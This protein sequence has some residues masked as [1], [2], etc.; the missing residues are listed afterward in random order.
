MNHPFERN[1]LKILGLLALSEPCA[2]GANWA[3]DTAP[4][5]AAYGGGNW[6]S[7]TTPGSG[8][9]TPASG[10]SLYFGTSSV[11]TLTNNDSN[12]TFGGFTYN[13]GAN[14][15]TNIGN[16]FTLLG[17][18][19][20]SSASLQ[21]ISNNIVLAANGT[22]SLAGGSLTLAGIISDGGSGYSLTRN[23]GSGNTLTLAGANTFSGAINLNAGT[24]AISSAGNL[25]NGTNIVCGSASTS[26]ISAAGAVTIPA[27]TTITAGSGAS[28]SAKETG[29]AATFQIAAL[30]TGAGNGAESSSLGTVWFSNPGNNYTGNFSMGYGTVEFNSVANGG[31][32]SSLGAG[33]TAY[34]IGN[35]SSAAMF[36]YL[37]SG[38]GTTTR[39][40]NW[41]ATT[42]G[43]ALDS[44]GSGAVQFL[45]TNAFRSAGSGANTL[46]LSGT[47][48][49]A[50]TLGQVI[51]DSAV[52]GA[53]T[54]VKTGAGT[55]ILS[56]TNTFSGATTISAGVLQL[57][58]G[59]ARNGSV[60]GAII[61]NASLVFANPTALNT[62]NSISGPGPLTKNAG[63]LL[64]LSGTNTYTGATMINSGTLAIGPTG[65][66]GGSPNIDLA[67]GAGFDVSAVSGG[68]TLAAGQ[69]L[70][71]V[72]GT[73]TING[74]LNL[75]SSSLSLTNVPG[76]P[77]FTVTGGALTLNNNSITV[78]VPGNPTLAAGSY[79]LIA[80]GSGGSVAGSVA[81]SPLALID[82]GNLNQPVA[83]AITN[84]GLW[85]VVSAT[86]TVPTVTT[87][88]SS[89]NP[90]TYG[91]VP[92]TFTATVS[93]APA[94]GE[95][96]AFLDGTNYL[97]AGQLTN[98]TAEFS[99]GTLALGSHAITAFFGQDVL[100]EA[101]TSGVLTQVVNQINVCYPQGTGF[102]LLMY[103]VDS[104]YTNLSVYGWNV[105]QQYGLVTNTD[106]NNFLAGLQA[107]DQTGPA[108]IPCSGTNDPFTG[109]TQA[110][111]QSWV[112]SIDGNTNIAWWS[113]PEQLLP[114]Y[115]TETNLL[116][117]YLTWTRQYDPQQRPCYEYTENSFTA[118]DMSKIIIYSDIVAVSCY[119]EQI[120]M[121]H[122][123]VRYKLQQVG[124]GGA[125]LAGKTLGP[126]Y[127]AG[128]K[129]LIGDL[130]IAEYPNTNNYPTEPTPA[131][132]YHD[133]W[134]AIASG[135]QGI[136]VY[137]YYH[138][139]N[140]DPANL[141]NCLL[142]ANIAASQ[143]TG[144]EQIGSV[145]LN[146]TPNT[147]V[148]F[149][150]TAGP[151]NTVAFMP[152]GVSTNIQYPSINVLSKTW[153]GNVYVIAVN[154]TSSNVTAVITNLPV[155]ES[156]AALPFEARL[157]T[158]TNRSFTDTFA[159]WGVHIYKLTTSTD[160]WAGGS[161]SK[162]STGTNWT[163][164]SGNGPVASGDS[165][166]FA[167]A[168]STAPTND[169]TGFTFNGITFESGAGAYTINGNA[170]TLS[171]GLANGSTNTQTINN[172]ILLATNLALDLSGG[173]LTLAGAISDGGNGFGL[174]RSGGSGNTLTLAGT[175]TFSG[176]VTLNGG[177]L[178]IG[179]LTNLGGGG[180]LICGGGSVSTV[181]AA[182]AVTIPSA[183]TVSVGGGASF[184][185][186][187]TTAFTTFQIA[188]QITGAGN[189]N[190]G[191]SAGTVWFSNPGNNYTGNFTMGYGTFQFSSVANGGTASSLGAGT[192]AY[193]IG[194]SASTA[195][196][197]YVGTGAS[198]TTRAIN[199]TAN[200]GALALD[201]GG[202]G[203]V[204]FLA[205]NLLRSGG[206][207]ADTLTL[208]GASTGA[209]TLAQVINDSPV[210]GA[211]SLVKAGA[212][213]W[214]LTGTNTYSGPTT[215]TGGTLQV[216]GTLGTNAVTVTNATLTGTG[217]VAGP[218]TFQSGSTL[219][220]GDN[221]I[222]TLSFG[223]S[224]TMNSGSLTLLNLSKN[225]G[226]LAN[227]A[228]AVTGALLLNGSLTVTN[229]G[230]NGLAAGDSFQI[231]SA[232]SYS[233]T[234]SPTLPPLATGLY[235][236]TN[237]LTVNGT[238]AVSN[239][240][241]TLAYV[242]GGGGSISGNAAQTVNYGTSGTA[243]TALP[244]TGYSFVNW[245][246]GS[247]ANP[248]TD[249]NVT[250][251]LSVTANFAINVY[252][253]TYTAGANGT[254]GGT[255]PQLVD[256]GANGTAVTAVPA[257][258]YHFVNWSDSSTAN[259][260]T[261][262]NV[263]GNIT[264]TASFAINT[265]TLT[266]SA[267][268]GGTVAGT[269]PQTVNYGASGTAMTATADAGLHFAGWSDG[270]TSNPRTDTDVTSNVT[271]TANF[272]VSTDTWAGATGNAFSTVANWSY[273]IFSGPVGTGDSLIFAAAGS[274]TPTN[275][276]TGLML[277]NIIFSNGASAYVINGNGF[278]LSGS[279]SNGAAN[280]QI[281]S[282]NIVLGT[283]LAVNL[284]AGSLTLAGSISDGG[285]GFSLTRASSGSGN[286]LTLA[287]AN[288]FTGGIYL[289]AGT[290]A[291]SSL[292]NLGGGNS[293]TCGGAS[294]SVLSAGGAITL[295]ATTTVTVGSG[296]SFSAK[297]ATSGMTFQVA[298]LITGTGNGNQSSSSGTVWLS[299]TGNNYTGNFGMG[300]GTLQYSSVAN[301]GTASAL[302]A[303][304]TA[305]TIGNS[306]SS[307]T[308]GYVG[309]GTSTTTRAINW[310]ATTG[311]LALDASGG[312]PVQFLATNALRSTGSGADTLTL[313]G[314]NT[315]ANTLAQVINDSAVAGATTLVK[316]GA[317][318]WV[319]TGANTC[320][321][322]TMVNG[323]TLQVDGSLGTNTVTVANTAVLAG[324]GTLGGATTV[325]SGGT[326]APGDG[327]IGTLN[328]G[329]SLALNGGS[330]SSLSLSKNGGVL[331]N[332]QVSV[333][334]AL[335]EGGLLAVANSGTNALAAGDSCRLFKA[336]SYAGGFTNVTLPAL[337]TGLTWYTNNLP[338]NGTIAVSN[339]TFTLTYTAGANGS[340][341]GTSPQTVI[342]GASGTAVTA[343]ANTN[344][345]F[346]KWSDG[347]G[348][349]PRTDTGVTNNITVS[350]IFTNGLPTLWLTNKVG[351]ISAAVTAGYSGKTFTL[352]GT[353]TG[354]ATNADG[355]WFAYLPATN[356]LSITAQV[357]S[358]QTNGTAP[359]AGVMIR[360]DTNAGSVFAFLGLS[361]TNN[362][363]W[364]Y[365]T[366][367]N[368]V[369]SATTFTNMPAPYW[370]QIIRGTNTFTSYVS[371]NGTAW[372]QAASVTITNMAT[373]VLVGL[374]VSAGTS[375]TLN[376][377]VFNNVV[378]TNNG[379]ILFQPEV[380]GAPAAAS[381]R[382][383]SFSINGGRESFTISGDEGSRWRLE[384][385]DDLGNWTAV[386][387]VTLIGGSVEQSQPH[388]SRPARFYRLVQTK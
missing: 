249:T 360:P 323:G 372:V 369:S 373:N 326:L 93:P 321:G 355:F 85:L 30:I 340:I 136:A 185:A 333:T 150:V 243:V 71:N 237:N 176:P 19:T 75:G 109:W 235:W 207:G 127:L 382:L 50:N 345:H 153:N 87:L 114:W 197:G 367:S 215:L 209:N 377:A 358:Q 139:E 280:A 101:S 204:Q 20:N 294:A 173:S 330:S 44:S 91:A 296:A 214:V 270:I 147:N 238:I 63:G 269:S 189:G 255:S 384:A 170:F 350:A 236:Y 168:G 260:R 74:S 12:F 208:Q 386:E 283:N 64:T 312:G 205:T 2:K 289:N 143:I 77:V 211:T 298:A 144:P 97:G 346:V 292:T 102:P 313:Q 252:T 116:G 301:G 331:T 322:P 117:N 163:Y 364:L 371:S 186:K 125:A 281:I 129:T 222:G 344:Y 96:V 69:T 41:T 68:Y 273:S 319:L 341:S 148:T 6:T 70:F 356:N 227:D 24:L 188:G 86:A 33:T 257:T 336:G 282:N 115:P 134:S 302:G 105:V 126:N 242:A 232:A 94:N 15:F 118:A 183:T 95:S 365:R 121:P 132:T 8:T 52:S 212:G 353:G 104:S 337:A 161:G 141:T 376:T 271:V 155:P 254:L 272:G 88:T 266:Y 247:T 231:V 218:A 290:L 241:F 279:I 72:G 34:T 162:F 110:A 359:L 320:S 339:L 137:S 10:D 299:N 98:G 196:F 328:F 285:N 184:A 90:S 219:A 84:G 201:S 368:T 159:P 23:G 138:A 217:L 59:A 295:P 244:N 37:G 66:I 31:S 291:I 258:G 142:Q 179:A 53:T 229:I 335:T 113:L 288:T 111:V 108:I 65:S 17:G 35:S 310:T 133:F 36:S 45:A 338:V 226:V 180:S 60:P 4:G 164:T 198:S 347:Y 42:G 278:T 158:M 80:T 22:L 156:S 154:D 199:W 18:I 38:T 303:G 81:S 307:A 385:S 100:Y 58:D 131:Q 48:T 73:G 202:S 13:S 27:T 363:K 256:Y 103:E 264:V 251:S 220:P 348:I 160:T 192:T 203:T 334:G 128:Q 119:C 234:F 89:P 151:T 146:G 83:L 362:A 157:V 361:P 387:T 253:L 43:L 29:A 329:G 224:L 82:E 194:N 274:A 233:G 149:L 343:V 287:G 193:T 3:W 206:S 122:A 259:P 248:R 342:Y 181:A 123:W 378:V 275:D 286:T 309:S 380:I 21:I 210:S 140:D 28:F 56:N 324:T 195:T 61:N 370:V 354:L 267:G 55:W 46:T 124:A 276:E 262:T 171:G 67:G 47:S 327:G 239:I 223:S 14:A 383:A 11:L 9:G 228:V 40:I 351:G 352:S 221:A 106:V 76:T 318:T 325:Q 152:P 306:A 51:N 316:S 39:A 26:V 357:T 191:S 57:G 135:A 261:D 165:L 305:Y 175:N 5:S 379:A 178:A 277:N 49:G 240:T 304:T 308:F 293:I 284:A 172:S 16:A 268:T 349:N 169:E 225:G 300:Y 250:A 374:A 54:L 92:V 317:G 366:A 213:T 230:T 187:E 297:E 174:T 177:T 25:G 216:D 315:G 145:I 32:A 1:L 166:I 190:A 246:D 381:A 79:E 182:G 167:A 62:T 130:S 245:S 311:A 78:T 388:D 200:T 263:S 7:G 265:Y 332:D 112:Q 314:T 107:N 375:N 99:T 120:N